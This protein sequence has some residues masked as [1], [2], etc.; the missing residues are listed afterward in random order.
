MKKG[1]LSLLAVA[2]TVVGCQNYDDQFDE[3]SDQITAL[4][5]TVQGLSTVADQIT[6]LQNTVN[7]LELTLGG[8]ISNIKTAVEALQTSLADVAT[9]ADLGLISS[10]LADVQADVKELLAANAVINQDITINNVATLEYVESLISTDADDPNVIV[11]GKITVEVDDTDFDDEHLARILAVTNKFATGLKTVT[12]SHTY[13]PS[14]NGPGPILTFDNLAFVDND[15]SVTGSTTLAD[16]D[17][18]N[19]K[20]RTVSGNLTIANVVG[21]LDLSLLT[22]AFDIT[23]PN[24]ITSLKMGGVNANTLKSAGTEAG[25]L[26][27]PK[28]TV[29]DGGKSKVVSVVANKATTIDVTVAATSTI[30][31]DVADVITI[32]GTAVT[33]LLDISGNTSGTTKVFAQ[34]IKTAVNTITTGS[35]AELHLTALTSAGTI[36]SGAKVVDLGKLASIS[37]K[38]AQITLN[39]VS[40]TLDLSALTVTGSV[41]AIAAKSIIIKN[42][43]PIEVSGAPIR[44]KGD[45]ATSLEIKELST[46]ATFSTAVD[47]DGLLPVL[48]TITVKGKGSTSSPFLTTITNRVSITSDKLKTANFDGTINDVYLDGMA[49]LTT[50]STKA[51]SFIRD[52]TLFGAEKITSLDLNHDHIEGSNAATLHVHNAAKLTTI[53]PTALDEVGT[54]SLTTLPKMTSLDFSSMKTLPVEGHFNFVVS[55]TGLSASYALGSLK[56]QTTPAFGDA[57]Y[58]DDLMT[59]LPIMQLAHATGAVTYTFAGDIISN[60]MTRTYND[61]GVA[62]AA[63]T[64]NGTATLA[65]LL[66]G[67]STQYIKTDTNVVTFTVGDASFGGIQEDTFAP[68]TITGTQTQDPQ[69]RAE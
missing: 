59:L 2:L 25:N 63:V 6:A 39:S 52:L 68:K 54:V 40:D 55:E 28:A 14:T 27:L 46:T 64:T 48:E 57:I 41:T 26:L 10:T 29:V 12:I 38:D 37:P 15:L 5:Q 47:V 11:N 20:L 49:L 8:D 21:D 35:L 19:D 7:G 67:D 58:S 42:H 17:S 34:K 65:D 13:S 32:D 60:V 16:G 4:S 3:L 43:T 31:G 66:N 36:T 30:Q 1:L 18:T 44:I 53:A 61:Q 9:A 69:V 51:G 33:G 50:L 56:S 23:V 22:S 45:A 24:D 62:T